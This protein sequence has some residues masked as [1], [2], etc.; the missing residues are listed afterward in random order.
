MASTPDDGQVSALQCRRVLAAE[1]SGPTCP[2]DSAALAD[3]T[4][5]NPCV[6]Y[7]NEDA[8]LASRCRRCRLDRR[9]RRLERPDHRPGACRSPA[10]RAPPQR[11]LEASADSSP[12]VFARTSRNA[13][14]GCG[15]YGVSRRW[16]ARPATIR[17]PGAD[18]VV[19]RVRAGR[20]GPTQ[21]RLHRVRGRPCADVAMR[22]LSGRPRSP[23]RRRGIALAVAATSATRS[24]ACRSG[25]ALAGRVTRPH[26]RARDGR[27]RER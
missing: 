14:S 23:V 3:A 6:T 10:R 15:A 4:P 8:W 2:P 1:T 11:V 17:R 16:S 12:G 27:G 18:G 25:A 24:S 26:R 13:G 5:I 9:R 19:Q 21:S 7:A 20:P 22:A